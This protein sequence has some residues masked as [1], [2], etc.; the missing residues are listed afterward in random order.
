MGQ[1]VS[2]RELLLRRGEWKRTGKGVVCAYGAFDLLHPGH[3]RLFERAR[4]FGEILAVA[5]QSNEIVQAG[6]VRVRDGGSLRVVQAERPITPAEERAEIVAALRAVDFSAVVHE[7][8]PEFLRTFQPDAFVCGDERSSK[9]VGSERD[10]A[11]D[12]ESMLTEIECKLVC[13]PLEPGFSTTRLIERISG[14]GA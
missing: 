5:I 13:L 12:L 8:L 11:A 6:A 4:D 3:I 7:G 2:Q 10:P 14:H 1:A 9:T